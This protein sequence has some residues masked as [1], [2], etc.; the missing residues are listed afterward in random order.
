MAKVPALTILEQVFF[1]T[2]FKCVAQLV[3]DYGAHL[4]VNMHLFDRVPALFTMMSFRH[5]YL[6][7]KNYEDYERTIS[8]NIPVVVCALVLWWADQYYLDKFKGKKDLIEQHMVAIPTN[9]YK[10]RMNQYVGFPVN[11]MVN[12]TQDLTTMEHFMPIVSVEKKLNFELFK[13]INIEVDY[14]LPQDEHIDYFSLHE[15]LANILFSEVELKYKNFYDKWNTVLDRNG[16]IFNTVND[17]FVTSTTA[18]LDSSTLPDETTK[19]DDTTKV[20]DDKK[21]TPPNC[22]SILSKYFPEKVNKDTDEAIMIRL[23]IVATQPNMPRSARKSKKSGNEGGTSDASASKARE[24]VAARQILDM[25][26]ETVEAVQTTPPPRAQSRPQSST[27]TT[28]NATT[29]ASTAVNVTTASTAVNVTNTVSGIIGHAEKSTP[30]NVTTGQQEGHLSTKHATIGAGQATATEATP[31][32]TTT[33]PSPAAKDHTA[34]AKKAVTAPAM[35]ATST[36]RN[37]KIADKNVDKTSAKKT[38]VATTHQKAAPAITAGTETRKDSATSSQNSEKSF[39]EKANERVERMSP[40]ILHHPRNTEIRVVM[41]KMMRRR[42]KRRKKRGVTVMRKKTN[43]M[44]T[45]TVI[46]VKCPLVE[47]R[48]RKRRRLLYTT[49]KKAVENR[50]DREWRTMMKKN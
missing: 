26:N 34:I 17:L 44:M 2:C 48:D 31:A 39:L 8:T 13:A 27:N 15:F 3:T 16:A 40:R 12:G 41:M 22:G 9:L 36:E 28:P 18:D 42:K 30:A 20:E 23:G 45:N 24:I 33:S 11:V 21:W 35:A 32:T 43:L 47:E 25:V 7:L 1:K 6:G 29:T 50:K 49:V 14:G 4:P 46:K 38:V 37:A 5:N 10:T 19:I